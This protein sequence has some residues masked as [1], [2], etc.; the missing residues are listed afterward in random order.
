MTYDTLKIE[1]DRAIMTVTLNRPE[2]RN[3]INRQMHLD[4]QDVCHRLASDFDTRVVIF[5]GE[6]A[7]FSAGA[8]TSEW[9]QPGPDNELELRHQSGIG[10]RSSNAIDSL[11]QISIA[12][13][14]GFAVGG[15]AVW[16]VC[17]DFRVGGEC[18][19]FSIPEV[20]L[21]IPLSWNA[22]PRLA[23]EVGHARALEMTVVCDKFGAQQALDWGL[24]THIVADGM[25]LS[26][27]RELADKITRHPALAVALTKASMRAIKRQTEQGEV[28]YSD[29]DLLLYSRL[30]QQRA[31]RRAKKD[32]S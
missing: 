31:R 19:W 7:G 6:G 21:G 9:G 26:A 28:A 15:G 4:I 16:A 13:V 25:E 27:A 23:R 2:K 10:S 14:N 5:T 18:A 22:L 11:D 20:E 1:R 17:C 8:D 12:A 30:L 32:E 24:L 3:A 29:G